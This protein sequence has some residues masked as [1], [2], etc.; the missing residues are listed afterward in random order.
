MHQFRLNFRLQN[1]LFASI[2]IFSV[3]IKNNIK[4]ILKLDLSVQKSYFKKDIIDTSN[5]TYLCRA[6][7]LCQ[8]YL[9]PFTK[10]HLGNTEM[11]IAKIL[12]LSIPIPK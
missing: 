11:L 4:K 2:L 5:I 3:S 6:T 1:I 9:N 7:N 10:F 12:I 8:I